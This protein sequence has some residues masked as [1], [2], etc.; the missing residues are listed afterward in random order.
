M[1]IA[2]AGTIAYAAKAFN[3]LFIEVQK[4]DATL[5]KEP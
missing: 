4:R 1:G 5:S 2:A 3:D